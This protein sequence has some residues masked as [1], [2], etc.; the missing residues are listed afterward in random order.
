MRLKIIVETRRCL[1]DK[2]QPVPGDRREIV[3]FVVISDVERDGIQYAVVAEGLLLIVMSEVMLLH[4][5]GAQGVKPNRKKEAEQQVCDGF[6]T[7]SDPDAGDEGSF[8]HPVERH[9]FVEWLDL[10]YAGDAEYLEKRIEQQPDDLSDKKVIDQPRLPAI[11]Q[12]R[13]ELMYSLD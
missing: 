4:P 3:V 8:R 13:I 11:G 1:L 12:V 5:T 10:A 2:G 9:P 6:R 7:K